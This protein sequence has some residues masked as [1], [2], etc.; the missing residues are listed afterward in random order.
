MANRGNIFSALL[1]G[2][3]D[4]SGESLS[5]GV[6]YFY[7]PGTVVAKSV[8]TDADLTAAVD[9]VELDSNGQAEVYGRGLYDVVVKDADGTTLYSW[10][11]V[12]LGKDVFVA[13][14]ILADYTATAD[15]S[16]ILVDTAGGNVVV[17][18]PDPATMQQAPYIVKT[19]SDANTVTISRSGTTI[20]GSANY[21]LSDQWE[22][23]QIAFDDYNFY[24]LGNYA[25]IATT[26][27]TEAT[28]DTA[29]KVELA[30]DA[31]AITGTDTDRAVTPS[32]LDAAIY[33]ALWGFISGLEVNNASADAEHDITISPG[34]ARDAG[35]AVFMEVTA[36]VTKQ[37]DANWVAGDGAGGFPSGLT[38]ASSTWYRVFLIRNPTTGVVDAGFDTDAT[39]TNLLADATGYTQ[40]RRIGWVLT[41]SSA[42]ILGFIPTVMQ[43]GAL[44]CLWQYPEYISAARLSTTGEEVALQA[45]PGEF[46]KVT[47]T[48]IIYNGTETNYMAN[49]LEIGAANPAPTEASS[50]ILLRRYEVSIN[51]VPASF[52]SIAFQYPVMYMIKTSSASKILIRGSSAV[53]YRR[54][55]TIGWLDRRAAAYVPAA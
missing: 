55:H 17:T 8:Y 50:S 42:N 39:A 1:A 18:L 20:N 51:G 40:Y 53:P 25:S 35:N 28:T 26:I 15:D 46:A 9:S 34:V 31:E 12:F 6:V 30:T 32:N 7:T 21:V 5:G 11:R 10:E 3:R 44:S 41:D 24:T 2:L 13:T 19:T 23:V 29:G 47:I 16:L 38:L 27:T 54:I 49:V 33:P 48:F 45:P 43:D 36:A 37:I 22:G 4:T 14:D 52:E